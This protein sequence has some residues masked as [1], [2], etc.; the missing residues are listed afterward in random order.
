MRLGV[1]R[2]RFGL[3]RRS[4]D[5]LVWS[6]DQVHSANQKFMPK[7]ILPIRCL[8]KCQGH[9]GKSWS[10]EKLQMVVSLDVQE[11]GEVSLPKVETC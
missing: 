1:N 11:G 8:A 4:V 3:A 7:Q 6:G 5:K 10:G 2:S 9:L